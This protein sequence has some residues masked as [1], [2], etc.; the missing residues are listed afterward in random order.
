MHPDWL[1]V[2]GGRSVRRVSGTRRKEH[3]ARCATTAGEPGIG[4]SALSRNLA[5]WTAVWLSAVGFPNLEVPSSAMAKVFSFGFLCFCLF[6][7][8]RELVKWSLQ[9]YSLGD[10]SHL[11][12]YLAIR[13]RTCSVSEVRC[14]SV[15]ASYP[16]PVNRLL[17]SVYH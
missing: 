6:P 15:S 2:P 4:A 14:V 5:V 10:G 17:F 3:R 16:P 11:T 1:Q 13:S 12:C 7:R 8:H 9:F